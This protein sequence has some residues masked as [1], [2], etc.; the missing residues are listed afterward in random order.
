MRTLVTF[1]FFF[2]LSTQAIFSQLRIGTDEMNLTFSGYINVTGI[3]DS[4]QVVAA[5]E[6]HLLLYPK[7]E[8]LDPSGTDINGAD[9]FQF[10]VIQ[11]RAAM[12]FKMK[13]FLGAETEATL[14]SEY[15][16]NSEADVNG[17]RIRHAF[18]SMKWGNKQVLAGQTWYPNYI[19]EV[20]PE[21]LSSNGGAPFVA[22][23]RAPQI[24]YTH[25]L[26]SIK[27][28]AAALTERDFP[29]VGPLGA[30]SEYSRNAV[31]PDLHAQIQFKSD[32]LFLGVGGEYKKLRP[33]IVSATGYANK[34]TV[35]GYSLTGYAKYT[36]GLFKAAVYGLYGAN[37]A[38]YLMISG[39]AVSE[40]TPTTGIESYK[41][42]KIFSAYSDISYGSDLKV[43]LFY[44]YQKNLGTDGDIIKSSVYV[45]G[46]DASGA[47]QSFYRVAPRIQYREGNT[48]LG[49][50]LE[51]HG[52]FYGK[53]S[54]KGTGEGVK[55]I[56]STRFVTTLY[57]YF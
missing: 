3:Y 4:R 32:P 21:E 9:A 39:F 48:L 37:V 57:Y 34:N 7:N 27:L 38:N 43:G 8:A 35:E 17:Y 46:I 53:T 44:G 42:T 33:R 52:A 28:I 20:A 22:F 19:P 16:G 5:R 23:G 1:L 10:A 14:E 13:S 24:R 36:T 12:K 45:R 47:L 54:A 49:A 25:E 30:S 40:L 2:V 31:F 41:P 51:Y 6:N 56:N 55:L 29:S 18:V 11:T 15:M 26:G 50:E